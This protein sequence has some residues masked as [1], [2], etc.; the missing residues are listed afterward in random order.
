MTTLQIRIDETTKKNAK[1][2]LDQLG[3]DMSVAIKLYFKQIERTKGIPFP[4]LTENGF[5][6]DQEAKLLHESN[7]TLRDYKTG[8]I[9][10]Y[11]STSA[12]MKD[13]LI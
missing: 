10:G 2:V 3:I 11:A 13:L 12:L 4:L 9:K 5:T 8:R 7:R 6:P 1:R